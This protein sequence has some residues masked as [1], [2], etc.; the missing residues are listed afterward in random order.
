M[1]TEMTFM[2]H[3]QELKRRGI[4]ILVTI[5]VVIG[6]VF[7]FGIHEV[8]VTEDQSYLL[9]VPNPFQNIASQLI[10]IIVDYT[11]P[12]FV[13][14]IVTAPGQAILSELFVAM[15]LGLL[16]GMPVIAYELGAFISPGLYPKERMM[17]VKLIAPVTALFASGAIFSYIFVVPF[18]VR[19]LYQYALE[20]EARAF[21]TVPDLISF[22]LLFLIA[23][24]VSFQLPV[25]MWYVTLVGVVNADFWKKNVRFA[26]VAIV[27]FGAV[28]TP[29]GSGVTMWLV[30]IPM[31]AL[32]LGGYLLIRRRLKSQPKNDETQQT[33]IVRE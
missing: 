5:V 25:I 4:K 20:L 10:K 24:G 1:S 11:T 31:M 29:D 2:E 3:M 14:L 13:E 30:A 17:V 7:I 12:D 27:I 28:I 8:Q 26:V 19:F 23:F 18:A 6:F 33:E 32:Y 22:V 9:P 21:I 16:I 15:F